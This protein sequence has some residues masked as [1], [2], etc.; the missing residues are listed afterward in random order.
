MLTISGTY[1][2]SLWHRYAIVVNQVM[3]VISP[4]PKETLAS[5]ASVL[6]VSSITKIMIGATR[7][8]ISYHLREIYSICIC[9]WNGATHK[10]KVHNGKI[11]VISFVLNRPSLLISRCKSRCESDLSLSVVSFISFSMGYMRSTEL[12]SERTSSS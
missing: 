12:F 11:D 9:C 4:L 8:R 2:F 3:V 10:C 6:P 1:R 5:V 7:S